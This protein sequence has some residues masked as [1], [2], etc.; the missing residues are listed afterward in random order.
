M[1]LSELVNLLQGIL[2]NDGDQP[3]FCVW[4]ESDEDGEEYTI[5]EVPFVYQS[6]FDEVWIT[7]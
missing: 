5:K 1:K 7:Y 3:V 6:V 4:S 2:K